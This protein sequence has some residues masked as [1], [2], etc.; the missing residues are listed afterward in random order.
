MRLLLRSFSL[1]MLLYPSIACA[2]DGSKSSFF[3]NII[4]FVVS[5]IVTGFL[6]DLF[7][8]KR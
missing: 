5:V 8:R 4:S 3:G 6:I 7:I 1:M 2:A